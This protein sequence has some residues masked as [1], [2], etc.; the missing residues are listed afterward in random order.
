VESGAAAVAI[1]PASVRHG[2]SGR[3]AP[4]STTSTAITNTRNR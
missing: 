3:A 2:L 1:G 4:D